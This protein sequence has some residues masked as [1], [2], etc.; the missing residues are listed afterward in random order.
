MECYDGK[1]YKLLGYSELF[2]YYVLTNRIYEDNRIFV[3]EAL[4]KTDNGIIRLS[5]GN[6]DN[7][8]PVYELEVFSRKLCR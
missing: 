4:I 3:R 5:E 1:K 6:S 8:A 2:N 7:K